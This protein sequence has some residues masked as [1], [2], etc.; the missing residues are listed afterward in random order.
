MSARGTIVP[1]T[2]LDTEL[3]RVLDPHYLDGISDRDLD[4]V[5]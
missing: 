5:R 1:M 4:E 2:W 3:K